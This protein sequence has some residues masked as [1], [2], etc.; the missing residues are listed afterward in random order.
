MTENQALKQALA[1]PGKEDILLA[2]ER[3]ACGDPNAFSPL[4]DRYV[5]PIYRYL[6][7]RL[8]SSDEAK[9]VTSQTFLA[10]YEAF[11]GYRDQGHFSAWLFSIARSKLVDHLRKEYRQERA[12]DLTLDDHTLDPLQEIVQSERRQA[13]RRL[14]RSLPEEELELLRLRYVAGI[15]FRDLAALLKKNE[16]AVKKNVYR[17]LARLH[18][19]LEA[20]DE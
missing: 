15:S 8:G 9:D 16:D 12:R 6:A 17:L 4:Y 18:S 11:P 5:Q 3:L 14:L 19:Q 1:G 2:Q 13:L 7:S 10:A 20:K